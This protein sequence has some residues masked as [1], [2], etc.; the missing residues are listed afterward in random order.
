MLEIRGVFEPTAAAPFVDMACA[1]R[2]FLKHL[3]GIMFC[4][5]IVCNK[6]CVNR[7]TKY[8]GLSEC[9][10]DGGVSNNKFI[11]ILGIKNLD[12][13]V[14][15]DRSSPAT[16]FGIDVYNYQSGSWWDE[17]NTRPVRYD[18]Q[19]QGDAMIVR[20]SRYMSRTVLP[21]AGFEVYTYAM[22]FDTHSR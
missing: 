13:G 6:S 3:A 20:C 9:K 15:L 19:R 16:S 1:H 18:L 5:S 21:P 17:V 11:I 2:K 22:W 14:W 8:T 10:Y 12:T 7:Y 4:D